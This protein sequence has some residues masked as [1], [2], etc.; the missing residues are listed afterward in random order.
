VAVS[1]AR[2]DAQRDTH[3]KSGRA[4]HL[5]RDVSHRT[6]IQTGQQYELE[7][8]QKVGPSSV[9][10]DAGHEHGV[11]PQSHGHTAGEGQGQAVGE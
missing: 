9:G 10:H 5:T 11:A 1:R 7:I 2:S 8:G 6:A 3:D 4:A